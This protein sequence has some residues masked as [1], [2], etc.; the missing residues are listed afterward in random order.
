MI[1][2]LSIF[3][4]DETWLIVVFVGLLFAI[5]ACEYLL[6]HAA[7]SRREEVSSI[8][9]TPSD[10]WGRDFKIAPKRIS[11]GA[12]DPKTGDIFL[13]LS[14]ISLKN[15]VSSAFSAHELSH[16]EQW[17]ENKIPMNIC[18]YKYTSTFCLM[19]FPAIFF[20][21]HFII[22]NLAIDA[23]GFVLVVL[24]CVIWLFILWKEF[25]AS[26]R[27]AIP[28]MLSRGFRQEEV[29]DA[30]HLLATAFATYILTF[31]VILTFAGLL[32]Q[33]VRAFL[34]P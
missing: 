22:G 25:D 20:Y 10:C 2:R 28:A 24:L 4:Q 5:A 13:S 21:L 6:H 30:K 1:Y 32:A 34:V 27:R 29:N 33:F 7:N 19:L 12:F 18:S 15:I 17:K 11:W 8:G 16:D 31:G 3:F 23:L 26:F 14:I 9:L